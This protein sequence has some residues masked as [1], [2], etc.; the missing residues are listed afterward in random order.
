M[1]EAPR[2]GGWQS[3]CRDK[4]GGDRVQARLGPQSS[5]AFE[6][7][8]AALKLVKGTTY[9]TDADVI[10]CLALDFID[11]PAADQADALRRWAP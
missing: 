10:E 7:V 11:R 4:R 9:C 1:T 5:A 2:R 3:I 8:R 6:S